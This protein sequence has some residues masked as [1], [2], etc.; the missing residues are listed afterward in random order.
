LSLICNLDADPRDCGS[1]FTLIAQLL[2]QGASEPAD[3]ARW[4]QWRNLP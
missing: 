4:P 3:F 1:R 2:L